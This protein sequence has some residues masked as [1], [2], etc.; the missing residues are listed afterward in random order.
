M[1]HAGKF[2]DQNGVL[3]GQSDQHD[4]TDLGIDIVFLAAHEQREES[5]GDGNRRAEEDREGQRPAFILGS[6]DEEDAEQR[7]GKDRHR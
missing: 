3:R 5:A 4:E 7:E 6:Q 1:L 2:D